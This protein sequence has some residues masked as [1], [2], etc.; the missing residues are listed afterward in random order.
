MSKQDGKLPDVSDLAGPM[1]AQVPTANQPLLVALAERVAARRYRAWA[2]RPELASY[3]DRLLLCAEREEEVAERIEALRPDAGAVQGSLAKQFPDF[4]ERYA[5]LFDGIGLIDQLLVQSRGERLG[6]MTWRSFAE[7]QPDAATRECLLECALL[8]ERSAVVLEEIIAG[9]SA[10]APAAH[11]SMEQLE[12]G[13]DEIRESPSD[14]GAL[15]MIVR[16]PETN[17]RE[18]VEQAQLDV[19]EGL[20]GDNWKARGYRG[21]PDGAAHPDM[22]LN[23]MNAR[24]AALVARESGRWSLAGD[25]LYVDLDL[26]SENLPPGTRLSLGDA[27]IEVTAEPHT[28]CKKFVSR[29]GLDAMKFVNSPVGRELNLRGIN[30]KVVESGAVRTGDFVAKVEG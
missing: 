25:Q 11:L 21:S 3:R 9:A 27:V 6:A 13:L 5:A 4:G 20:I 2:D 23:L 17:R 24:V 26:S 22:Q 8:E 14:R 7:H 18:V 28:G 1:L 15:R 16:R 10:D 29:F 19:V 30:A 12:A